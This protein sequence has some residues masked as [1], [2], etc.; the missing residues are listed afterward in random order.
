VKIPVLIRIRVALVKAFARM[1]GIPIETHEVNLKS[2]IKWE[3][4]TYI[5]EAC[6][7]LQH[8]FEQDIKRVW[9]FDEWAYDMLI[10]MWDN[11][12]VMHDHPFEL[13]ASWMGLHYGCSDCI[14]EMRAAEEKFTKFWQTNA[15]YRKRFHRYEY[16]TPDETSTEPSVT[17]LGT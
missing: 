6:Y 4:N 10:G 13:A 16:F 14:D 12:F 7:I 17:A 3:I 1:F 5:D 2:V 11:P 9:Q 15:E 8:V